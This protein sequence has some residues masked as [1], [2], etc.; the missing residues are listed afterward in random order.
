M[1]RNRLSEV[2]KDVFLQIDDGIGT[3]VI[4]RPEKQNAIRWEM[5]ESLIHIVTQCTNNPEVK[6]MIFRSSIETTFSSGA[7]ITEFKGIYHNRERAV[8]FNELPSK[9]EK[10]II[11]SPKPS[12]ALIQGFC[13]GGGC[14]IALA[15]D[16]RFTDST[17]KFGITPAKL[18]LVYNTSGTKRLVDLVGPSRAKDLL[19]SGRII[20]AEEAFQMGLVNRIVPSEELVEETYRY[21]KMLAKNA[22]MSLSGAKKIIEDIF[23]GSVESSVEIEKMAIDAYTSDDFKEG[24]HAFLEKRRPNFRGR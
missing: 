18:G 2:K 24:V 6:V 21:A 16:F 19:F 12:I 15:C 20:D 23:R 5:W 17:G 8:A 7:D 4:N 22:P 10:V 14:Q 3:I 11:D 1:K 9:L 13:V